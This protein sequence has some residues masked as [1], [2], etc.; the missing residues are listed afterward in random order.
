M[1]MYF[2]TC[3]L[4]SGDMN[5]IGLLYRE[6]VKIQLHTTIPVHGIVHPCRDSFMI[7]FQYIF[8][9][10]FWDVQVDTANLQK[11]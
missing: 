8:D 6:Y 1:C 2:E 9:T 10:R 4:E 5:C 7:G 3:Q 11:L